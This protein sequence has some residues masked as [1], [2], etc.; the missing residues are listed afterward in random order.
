MVALDEM[1]C[2]TLGGGRP[3]YLTNLY[4]SCDDFLTMRCL[5]THPARNRAAVGQKRYVV[6]RVP[7]WN[8]ADCA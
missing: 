2:H 7:D 1:G 3:Q 8:V 6:G 4:T 5:R